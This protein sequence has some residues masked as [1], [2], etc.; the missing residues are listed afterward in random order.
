MEYSNLQVLFFQHVKARLQPHL[1]LAEELA[2]ILHISTDSAYRRMR[3]EKLITLE[4]VKT[5]ALHFDISIDQLLNENSPRFLFTDNVIKKDKYD[6]EEQLDFHLNGL[7]SLKAMGEVEITYFS[8][9]IAIYYFYQFPELLA[10]KYFYWMQTVFEN[11]EFIRRKFLIADYSNV[12]AEKGM[13][14]ARLYSEIPSVE[15]WALEHINLT[16]QQVQV[17][18]ES[19][20]L[21]NPAE[22]SVIYDKLIL[23]IDHIEMQAETGKKF[24][25]NERVKENAASFEL[26]VNEF[27]IGGNNIIA[28]AG[29][30]YVAFINHSVMNYLTTDNPVFC[31][32]VVKRI[33]NVIKKSDLISRVGEKQRKNF[34]NRMRARIESGRKG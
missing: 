33:Q 34:F 26:Y 12:F 31:D 15:I 6:F 3:G 5:L 20:M 16:L 22:S 27:M 11:P 23:M 18:K 19:D 9:D 29:N 25:Y 14:A 28:K 30:R 24:L 1:S 32:Y 13:A 17:F 7:N 2:E 4:E 21:E 8:R 10:F